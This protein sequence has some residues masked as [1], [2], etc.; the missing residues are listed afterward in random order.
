MHRKNTVN[1]PGI[2]VINPGSSSLKWAYFKCL[3]AASAT[4]TGQNN[5]G[6][7]SQDIKTLLCKYPIGSVVIRFVHGGNEFVTPITIDNVRL[8]TLEELSSLA[9]LHNQQALLASKD[10]SKSTPGLRQIAVFDTEFFHDLPRVAQLYGLPN[11]LIVKYGIRR[12]GFHGFAHASMLKQWHTLQGRH[13]AR[14]IRLITIQLG[15]GCSMAAIRNDRPVDSTMGFTPNDGLLMSTRC[16][17]MDPGLLTWLQKQE[18]WSPDDTDRIL[19]K[20]SGWLGLSG[21]SSNMGEL[22]HSNS[23][24]AR[25]AVDLFIH[26]IRKTL[27]AYFALLGGLDGV[28]F[29]GGIPERSPG[30]CR[31]ILAGLEHLGIV[32]AASSPMPTGKQ[33]TAILAHPLTAADSA[34]ACWTVRS[35]EA[36]SMLDSVEN[37]LD[38]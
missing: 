11:E 10:I 9:P 35:D 4:V 19:N 12:F 28:V 13:N 20:K 31:E 22:L 15:S 26:R 18:D 21:E 17:D 34:A 32:C 37:H 3:G 8:R 38:N 1:T 7:A 2:L 16:G 6:N 5:A 36:R 25:L 33:E 29:S 14:D 27:G 24:A 30:V 23:V